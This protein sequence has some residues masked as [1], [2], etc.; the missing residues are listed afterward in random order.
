MEKFYQSLGGSQ[1]PK[2]QL[3]AGPSDHEASITILQYQNL[4]ILEY[5]VQDS[6]EHL[7]AWPFYAA[8]RGPGLVCYPHEDLYT[9]LVES[10]KGPKVTN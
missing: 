4:N 9:I 8:S 2:D 7:T 5:K 6:Y 1:I 10:M 3:I